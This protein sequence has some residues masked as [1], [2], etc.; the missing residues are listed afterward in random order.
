MS[1][2]VIRV[3]VIGEQPIFRMGLVSTLSGHSGIQVAGESSQCADAVRRAPGLAV[4]VFLLVVDGIPTRKVTGWIEALRAV[5]ATAHIVVLTD[6]LDAFGLDQLKAAGA[7]SLLQKCA[8]AQAILQATWNPG[9][10]LAPVARAPDRHVPGADLTDRERDLLQLMALGLSNADIAQRLGV[11]V[12]TVKFHIGNIMSKLQAGNRTAAVLEAL[13][14]QLVSLEAAAP[15]PPDAP[16]P[17]GLH[18]QPRVAEAS[19]AG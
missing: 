8:T 10:G 3:F 16:G 17:V 12:S 5:C 13:R 6:A 11:A 9:Y 1:A 7:G 2:P 15:M 19:T 18:E 14:Y 4:Q